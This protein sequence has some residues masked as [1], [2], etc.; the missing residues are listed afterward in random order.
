MRRSAAALS[1]A[2]IFAVTT[3][4]SRRSATAAA[5]LS[6]AALLTSVITTSKP[7]IAKTWAIPLPIVPAPMIPI[8]RIGMSPNPC[9]RA[10]PTASDAPQRGGQS[11]GADRPQATSGVEVLRLAPRFL[12][13]F[14]SV[15]RPGWGETW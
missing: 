3:R 15:G 10:G 1:S 9:L 14:Y 13:P 2:D 8:V 7:A 11:R 6:A 5:P 12:A 4:R